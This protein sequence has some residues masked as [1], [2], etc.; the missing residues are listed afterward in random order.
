MSLRDQDG[1]GRS[2]GQ[3][4]DDAVVEELLG[5]GYQGDAPDL[6][7]VSQFVERVRCFAEQPVAPPS[8][9]LA[10]VLHD[11]AAFSSGGLPTTSRRRLRDLRVA[12]FGRRTQDSGRATAA[13]HR[14]RPLRVPR[15]AVTVSA[16]LVAGVVVVAAG[17]ARLLPGPTQ[18]L[19]AKIVRAV[20]PVELPQHRKPEARPSTAPRPETAP[21]SDSRTQRDDEQ[22]G[23]DAPPTGR[24]SAVGPDGID[25]PPSRSGAKAAPRPATTVA[26]GGA[27]TVP[28]ADGQSSPEVTTAAPPP[29]SRKRDFRADLSGAMDAQTAGDADGN[30]K[31]VLDADAETNKLCLRLHVARI[32]RITAVHLHAGP[33]GFSGAD[34]A[35]FTV[36]SGGPSAGCVTVTKEVMTRI[37]TE[38][39]NHYVDVHTTEFPN[40][41]LRGQLTR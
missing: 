14:S 1:Q 2:G 26:P 24:S 20:T 25:G 27:P 28:A 33:L 39:Q 19:V 41:A 22:P 18:D 17:S 16:V 34:V 15:V 3:P 5:G 29:R 11:S 12:A 31:A 38:P 37:E 10:H 7:A 40:G 8:A 4:L 21:L 36:P 13:P 6:V 30:G 32:D 23:T 9:A 35:T